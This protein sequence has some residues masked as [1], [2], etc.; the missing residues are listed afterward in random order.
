MLHGV[1]VTEPGISPWCLRWPVER[2]NSW[3]SNFGQLRR[4]TDPLTAHRL[5]QFALADA[6]IITVKL[7]K[8]AKRWDSM[9]VA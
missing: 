5:A 1:E 8:W 3:L 4:N 7:V 6:L 9:A 2:T